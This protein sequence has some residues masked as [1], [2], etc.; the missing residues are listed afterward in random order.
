MEIEKET[1]QDIVLL[2]K[3]LFRYVDGQFYAAGFDRIVVGKATVFRF[4]L[5]QVIA[6]P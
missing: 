2:E 4:T 6:K 1:G 3:T 5:F